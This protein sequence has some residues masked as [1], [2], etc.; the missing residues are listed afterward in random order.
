MARGLF[1][2]ASIVLVAG[3]LLGSVGAHA[4]GPVVCGAAVK[5]QTLLEGGRERIYSVPGSKPPG[6]ERIFG[7]LVWKGGISI[8]QLNRWPKHAPYCCGRWTTVDT[9]ALA[10]RA[11]WVA[12]A[13]SFSGIDTSALTVAA[14][15]LRQGETSYCLVGGRRAPRRGP[16][17][18]G[19]A[20][21]RNGH[22]AWIGESGLST[23]EIGVCASTEREVKGEVI[24]SGDGIDLQSLALHDSTLTWTDS[25]NR[26]SATLP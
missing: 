1:A 22:R 10:I 20:L 4:R 21:R 6:T 5:G 12:Y 19:I 3:A 7:C 16:T 2:A 8:F 26:Q 17:V 23:P 11:P 15:D 24:A 13:E 18:T 25:G 14:M 9:E